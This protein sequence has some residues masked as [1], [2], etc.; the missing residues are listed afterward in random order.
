[1]IVP[2]PW[3][4]PIVAN[5]MIYMTAPDNIWAVDAQTGQV[6]WKT[7]VDD[8]AFARV[9]ASPVFHDGRLYVGVASGEETAGA[10]GGA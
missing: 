7:K 4:S 10:R 9:T 5:G 3:S 8:H 1:M 2:V 6:I